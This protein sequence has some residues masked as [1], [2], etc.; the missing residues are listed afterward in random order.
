MILT[1]LSLMLKIHNKD[2]INKSRYKYMFV[3]FSLKKKLKFLN[4]ISY[5]NYCRL[6][7]HKKIFLNL[8]KILVWKISD[9]YILLSNNSS[10]VI[11]KN[12]YMSNRKKYLGNVFVREYFKFLVKKKKL[13]ENNLFLNK[14]TIKNNYYLNVKLNYLLRFTHLEVNL[15]KILLKEK[16]KFFKRFFFLVVNN[17]TLKFFRKQTNYVPKRKFY[18][19]SY[20][21][22]KMFRRKRLFFMRYFKKTFILK[23]KQFHKFFLF[24]NYY[25]QLDIIRSNRK[26]NYLNIRGLLKIYRKW[27]KK[28]FYKIKFKYLKFIFDLAI[29]YRINDYLK[30][31]REEAAII[32]KNINKLYYEKTIIQYYIFKISNWETYIRFI[33]N[34]KIDSIF[35]RVFRKFKFFSA[36]YYNNSW[37]LREGY[38]NKMKLFFLPRNFIITLRRLHFFTSATVGLIVNKKQQKVLRSYQIMFIKAFFTTY[39]PVFG[40]TFSVIIEKPSKRVSYFFFYLR[41][42]IKKFNKEIY[43]KKFLRLGQ[44]NLYRTFSI[45]NLKGQKKPRRKKFV[46]KKKKRYQF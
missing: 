15:K 37:Y 2:L 6:E 20:K 31:F 4:F 41:F 19:Y 7:K 11:K 9:E 10:F 14:F 46:I 33:T 34:K 32:K 45:N 25:D 40:R 18:R 17:S 13:N 12:L 23:K 26:K 16:K 1:K 44:L 3:S 29:P 36:Y 27:K 8:S 22:N 5:Y 42:F 38:I 43:K 21:K 30:T 35:Y 39:Q 24:K 28:W